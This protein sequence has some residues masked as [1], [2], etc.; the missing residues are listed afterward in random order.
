M[1]GE[2]GLEMKIEDQDIF[3]T[4]RRKREAEVRVWGKEENEWNCKGDGSREKKGKE[5]ERPRIKLVE[6]LHVQEQV[7][8][9]EPD[10]GKDVF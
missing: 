10:S 4:G 8:R 2:S 3:V 7:K 5:K 1:E 6:K 9:V